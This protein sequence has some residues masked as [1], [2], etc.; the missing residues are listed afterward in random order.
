MKPVDMPLQKATRCS[1][2]MDG[3]SRSDSIHMLTEVK[4]V[5]SRRSAMPLRGR[6]NKGSSATTIGNSRMALSVTAIATSNADAPVP[7]AETRITCAGPAHTST[8]DSA[9]HQADRPKSCA[10]APMP[11]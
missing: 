5:G 2:G 7:I 1:R 4:C 6:R 8:V 11:T 9:S 3:R 10:S